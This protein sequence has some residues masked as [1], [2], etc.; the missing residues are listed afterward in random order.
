MLLD[1]EADADDDDAERD[2]APSP[3]ASAALSRRLTGADQRFFVGYAQFFCARRLTRAERLKALTTDEHTPAR[4]RVRGALANFV[5]FAR[6]FKCGVDGGGGA[7]HPH[8]PSSRRRRCNVWI[9]EL[10]HRAFMRGT[11]RL[12]WH[13]RRRRAPLHLR[14]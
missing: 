3:V 7:A 6:A 11:H 13:R 9:D 8:F 4:F 10:Q 14:R 5:A 12:R 1:T 2:D